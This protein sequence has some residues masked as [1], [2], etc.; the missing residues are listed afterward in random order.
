MSLH[1]PPNWSEQPLP[2][3]GAAPALPAGLPQTVRCIPPNYAQCPPHQHF[4][5]ARWSCVDQSQKSQCPAGWSAAPP[6]QPVYGKPLG[7]DCLPPS[8]G[9][10]PNQGFWN[11]ATY[12]CSYEDAFY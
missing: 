6:Q 5:A 12:S 8:Y 2:V 7:V 3:G 9:V 10:C 11:G 1:C 4:D